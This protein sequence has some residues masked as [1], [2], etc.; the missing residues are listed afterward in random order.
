V[1]DD[2]VVFLQGTQQ[3]FQ[4]SPQ[5]I[6]ELPQKFPADGRTYR[7]IAEQSAGHP[8]RSNPTLAIEGCL[9]EGGGTVSTG[10]FTQFPE[11]D[12]NP[13]VSV[14]VSE[15]IGSFEGIFLRG[16]PKG[17]GQA[18]NIAPDTKIK[19]DV[20]LQ[21][22]FGTDT[23]RRIVIKDTLPE[24]LDVSTLVMGAGSHPYKY[25]ITGE[26]VLT[27][28][29]ERLELQAGEHLFVAFEI[30]PKANVP[31][32]TYIENN[33][34]VYF[35]VLAPFQTNSVG[36]TLGTLD[37]FSVAVEHPQV[38][39]GFQVHVF[40]NPFHASAM[41]EIKSDRLLGKVNFLLLDPTGRVLRM[42]SFYGNYFELYRK[43]LSAGMYYF[44]LITDGQIINSG[45][46]VIR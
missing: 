22:N 37:E 46:L 10:F 18:R 30:A 42:E 38:A 3:T 11:D 13:S 15:I 9:P 33:A 2:V 36:H 19:Y 5:Q 40:P 6:F 28:I 12:G 17:Y 43:D 1:E 14:D 44:Q 45:K 27:I 16:Y 21:H 24:S 41:F 7:V 39:P 25:E 23:I 4:L 8:G 35:D 20:L 26:S 32:G 29:F 31:L 34:T